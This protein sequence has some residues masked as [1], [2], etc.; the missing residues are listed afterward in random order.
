MRLWVLA[1]FWLKLSISGDLPTLEK[2]TTKSQ[3]GWYAWAQDA[4]TRVVEYQEE[5]K[6][7]WSHVERS[8]EAQKLGQRQEFSR[9]VL[10]TKTVIRWPNL[11]LK[12]P[13]LAGVETPYKIGFNILTNLWVVLQCFF[14]R[15]TFSCPW[16]TSLHNL[17]RTFFG[18]HRY[19][20]QNFYGQFCP[21]LSWHGHFQ[22]FLNIATRT[23]ALPRALFSKLPRAPKFATGKKTQGISLR[24][25]L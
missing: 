21:V 9:Q 20:F 17:P 3:D 2:P 10:K 1:D 8:G 25:F 14:P 4:L 19:F 16:Q 15:G 12:D 11:P 22:Q 5:P 24:I 23:F 18:V 13:A 7:L 6:P